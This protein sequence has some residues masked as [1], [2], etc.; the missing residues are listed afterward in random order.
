MDKGKK[1]LR[2]MR[3]EKLSKVS[4]T[5]ENLF[6][7]IIQV[8]LRRVMCTP[9]TKN[10]SS[11][12]SKSAMISERF[13]QLGKR[14]YLFVQSFINM[15]CCRRCCQKLKSYRVMLTSFCRTELSLTLLKYQSLRSMSIEQ[16]M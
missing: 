11:G 9:K 12:L 13:F 7:F 16:S 10:K 2:Y 5:D 6:D 1:L 3:M 14:S 15:S 4:F 8:T